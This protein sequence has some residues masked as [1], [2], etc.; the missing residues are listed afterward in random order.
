MSAVWMLL[1]SLLFA[2]MGACVKLAATDFSSG[3]LVFWRGLF[4]I[5]VMVSLARAT[6]IRLATP[7]WRLHA[8]R[9][10]AGA[11]ALL[12]YFYALS[13]LSLAT[14][15]TLNYTSPL[16]VAVLSV[17][18]HGERIGRGAMVAIAGGLAGVTLVLQPSLS[19]RLWDGAIAGL[20]CGAI[21]SFA[22]LSVR[23]LG[24][25]G[26]PEVRTVFWFS[27]TTVVLGAPWL[28]VGEPRT[29]GLTQGLALAGVGGFGAAA[30]LAMTRAYARGPTVLTACLAYTTVIFSSGIGM[31]LWGER[32][33][34]ASLAGIALIVASGCGVA[35][36]SRRPKPAA[37]RI[38]APDRCGL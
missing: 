7:H 24:R 18:L 20:A 17:L 25:A 12:C 35:I 2:A 21:A 22:Y 28:L 32:P 26:E 9:S 4:G 37:T 38:E 10:L 34:P 14:A 1:A 13:R 30:Q 23:E 31:L 33:G 5:V 27:L 16:F 8:S 6:R 11:I 36:L 15:V 19:A 29:Y 3:E